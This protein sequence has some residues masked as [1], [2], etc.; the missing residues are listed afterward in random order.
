MS[1]HIE[2]YRELTHSML[3]A[4]AQRQLSLPQI[5]SVLYAC[6]Q[7]T[8][9]ENVIDVTQEVR[10]ALT[11]WSEQNKGMLIGVETVQLTFQCVNIHGP[12]K[13]GRHTVNMT[14]V[15]GSMEWE[16]EQ[17]QSS[18]DFNDVIVQTTMQ[19]HPD[20]PDTKGKVVSHAAGGQA[21]LIGYF[22]DMFAAQPDQVVE[23]EISE[24]RAELDA[25]FPS[26][27]STQPRKEESDG[28]ERPTP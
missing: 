21:D 18:L 13:K 15:I 5:T 6:A 24:F 8:T 25:L 3:F 28:P 7:P 23:K 4:L 14:R 20:G 26:V 10:A 19:H 2:T 9:E 27:P 17:V 22:R 12:C 1:V 11:D 16:P